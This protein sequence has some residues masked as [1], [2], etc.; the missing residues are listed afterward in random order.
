MP[1]REHSDYASL[2]DRLVLEHTLDSC[3]DFGECWV[4]KYGRY[5]LVA[6]PDTDPY[7]SV[8]VHFDWTP[9]AEELHALG[10]PA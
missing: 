8:E 2:R 5:V 10:F 6:L 1:T 4:D 3:T 9:T 7:E